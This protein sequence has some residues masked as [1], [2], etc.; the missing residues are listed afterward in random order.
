MLTNCCMYL[1]KNAQIKCFSAGQHLH[2]FIKLRNSYNKIVCNDCLHGKIKIKK[3]LKI[4]VIIL[5]LTI[6]Q[7]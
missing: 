6:C 4:L 1:Q 3:F 5:S 2:D 7:E